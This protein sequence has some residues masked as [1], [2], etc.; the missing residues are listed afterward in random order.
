M[1][2]QACVKEWMAKEMARTPPDTGNQRRRRAYAQREL[3]QALRPVALQ[4][5]ADDAFGVRQR[6][7]PPLAKAV[8]IVPVELFGPL[9]GRSAKI[10]E[11]HRVR[12][13]FQIVV[14]G[15]DAVDL[16]LVEE[17]GYRRRGDGR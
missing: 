16:K 14:G 9:A 11:T 4:H 13:Q 15:H 5:V 6:P 2:F 8:D 17:A 1:P 12:L 10:G 7:H 3:D